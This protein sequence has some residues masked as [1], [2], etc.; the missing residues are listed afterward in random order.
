MKR[1][2]LFMIS[3]SIAAY[4]ACD[5]ISKLKQA[6]YNIQVVCTEAALKFV[7]VASLEALSGRPVLWKMFE[8]NHMLDHIH[9]AKWAE[10]GILCPATANSIQKLAHGLADNLVSCLYLASDPRKPFFIAPAMNQQMFAHP[11]IEAGLTL[12]TKRGATIIPPAFG[13]QACGD[14]GTGRLADPMTIIDF[15]KGPKVEHPAKRVLVIYGGTVEPIDAVRSITNYSSGKTGAAICDA[16]SLYGYQVQCIKAKSALVGT[17]IIPTQIYTTFADLQHQLENLEKS[18]FDVIIH[19]AAVSDYA[20]ANYSIESQP[21]TSAPPSKKIS[22]EAETLCL[23][24]KR[25]PKLIAGLKSIGQQRPLLIGFKLTFEASAEE[26]NQSIRKLFAQS[27]VDA[28][29]HNDL[30]AI[31]NENHTFQFYSSPQ[32][33]SPCENVQAL[34]QRI[35][36]FISHPASHKEKL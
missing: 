6:G 22:S 28:V 25:N 15:I 32:Q 4:K 33:Q 30:H 24:L 13:R 14:V 2:I 10:L 21:L 19:L 11:A 3:G 26:Q 35:H 20:V 34:C 36:Q 12:L 17:Q 8:P 5:I 27:P 9:L 18:Q 31:Q 1:N 7:G 23:H 16:L 29:V